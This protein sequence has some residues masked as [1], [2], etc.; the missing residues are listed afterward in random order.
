MQSENM[1]RTLA[2]YRKQFAGR[3]VILAIDELMRLSGISFKMLAF[4]RMLSEDP[5]L[6][7]STLLV[8][9]GISQ[10]V[11]IAFELGY[12]ST[13]SSIRFSTFFR[14]VSRSSTSAAKTSRAS[15]AR[16]RS[17]PTASTGASVRPEQNPRPALCS[18]HF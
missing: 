16:T 9:V 6:A 14:W 11:S 18:A 3:R 17:S 10:Y 2:A 5:G 15:A 1:R 4:E 7:K 8:Q 12:C 13:L